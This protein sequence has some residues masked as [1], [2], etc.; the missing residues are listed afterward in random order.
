MHSSTPTL[1]RIFVFKKT[2]YIFYSNKL[3]ALIFLTRHPHPSPQCPYMSPF[4]SK[5]PNAKFNAT[6]AGG[7]QLAALC[8]C[9]PNCTS[10][11][12]PRFSRSLQLP[13]S[14]PLRLVVCNWPRSTYVP[15]LHVYYLM[16]MSVSNSQAA[17]SSTFA[18]LIGRMTR[19]TMRRLRFLDHNVGEY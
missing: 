19:V 4:L 1:L 5:S 10:A 11:Q 17:T 9:S 15:Q 3:L 14:T 12:P 6:S 2:F 16:L 13:N 18:S 8:V 7:V